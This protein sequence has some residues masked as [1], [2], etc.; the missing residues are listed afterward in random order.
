MCSSIEKIPNEIFA[1]ILS[2]LNCVDAVI[3]FGYLNRRIQCLLDEYCRSFDL[4]ST[5]KTNFDSIFKRQ[6]TKR[7]HS[8][9]LSDRA[10]TPG[11]VRYFLANHSL[12]D[13]FSQLQ[14]LSVVNILHQDIL[15]LF[16]QI[17]FLSNLTSLEIE[18][19][20]G[21]EIPE[22]EFPNLKNLTITTCSDTIW[23]KV[24]EVLHHLKLTKACI[25]FVG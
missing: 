11:Q 22:F 6:N 15:S 4:T 8:L 2:Y 17:P 9:K 13:E 19:L 21:K 1:E 3:A 16:I 23:F 12:G 25:F 18:S 5:N 24:I 10:C 14:S 7:W 20:C